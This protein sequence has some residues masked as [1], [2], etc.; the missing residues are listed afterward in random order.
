MRSSQ[1]QVSGDKVGDNQTLFERDSKQ[2]EE[3]EEDML[4]IE[5]QSRPSQS[6]SLTNSI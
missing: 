6:K 2:D 1:G 4:R 5:E 3:I